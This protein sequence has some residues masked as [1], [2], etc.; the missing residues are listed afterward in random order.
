MAQL[1]MRAGAAEQDPDAAGMAQHHRPDPQQGQGGGCG[2]RTGR[3]EEH[4]AFQ[5]Q[6]AH[7]L[8]QGIG[9][10]RQQLPEL[11]WARNGDKTPDRQRDPTAD[12]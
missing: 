1:L 8:D 4:R 10:S 12:P 2:V 6:A 5:C 7:P 3:G 9:Q 11:G